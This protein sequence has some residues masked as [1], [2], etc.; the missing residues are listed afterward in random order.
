MG[1]QVKELAKALLCKGAT[2][3]KERQPV[4]RV[5]SRK[6]KEP[7]SSGW[8]P[9]DV[10]TT[11]HDTASLQPSFTGRSSVS[12][13]IRMPPRSKL[14]Q[15]RLCCTGTGRAPTAVNAAVCVYR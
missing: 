6:G 3:G 14:P 2:Q 5:Y 1:W 7:Q 4:R 13:Q 10:H 9:P 15:S 12:P 8:C 11:E